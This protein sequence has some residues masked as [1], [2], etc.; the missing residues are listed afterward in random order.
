M[1]Y[2]R[3]QPRRGPRENEIEFLRELACGPKAAGKGPLGLCL[4]RG[5]CAQILNDGAS[6]SDTTGAVLYTITA[7]GLEA[8]RQAHK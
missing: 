7:E 4:K 1:P 5:W 6:S 3:K 2:Q 8:L